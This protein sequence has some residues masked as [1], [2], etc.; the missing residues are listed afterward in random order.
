MSIELRQKT[1]NIQEVY[2][3]AVKN[4][5]VK[6]ARILSNDLSNSAPKKI[7]AKETDI[8]GLVPTCESMRK[9]EYLRAYLLIT[10]S[11]LSRMKKAGRK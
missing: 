10:L 3:V 9:A 7:K 4:S 2:D 6:V 5:Q 11:S 1:L 8:L